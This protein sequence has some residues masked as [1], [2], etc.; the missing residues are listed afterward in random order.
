MEYKYCSNRNRQEK[1]DQFKENTESGS[2]FPRKMQNSSPSKNHRKNTEKWKK[3]GNVQRERDSWQELP[4]HQMNESKTDYCHFGRRWRATAI[5]SA[6]WLVHFDIWYCVYRMR[7]SLWRRWRRRW[8]WRRILWW[9]RI[10]TCFQRIFVTRKI[11]FAGCRT[12][13]SIV[14]WWRLKLWEWLMW[15]IKQRGWDVFRANKFPRDKIEKKTFWGITWLW[16]RANDE[17]ISIAK[18]FLDF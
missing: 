7:W 14:W 9:R 13:A 16:A 3:K 2:Q 10:W 6:R 17:T 8:R 18:L 4:R 15:V 5:L 11:F 12:D 1:R